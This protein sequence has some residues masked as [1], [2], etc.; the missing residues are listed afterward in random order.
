M[1]AINE[2]QWFSLEDC[3]K[4][5]GLSKESVRQ[6]CI[7]LD[8]PAEKH[9]QRWM[10]HWTALP[11]G[12][13][14]EYR[15][16][17]EET[18]ARQQQESKQRRLDALEPWQEKYLQKRLP[19]FLDSLAHCGAQLREFGKRNGMSYQTL[20]RWRERYQASGKDPLSLI[21]IYKPHAGNG[22]KRSGSPR[23]RSGNGSF[24]TAINPL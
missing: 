24:K 14:V 21:P 23:G 15:Q 3:S 20:L 1:P 7:S 10:I 19:I 13:L 18:K 16:Q 9:G 2:T 17:I 8:I 11:D 4:L 12:K 5:M 6:R 22:R